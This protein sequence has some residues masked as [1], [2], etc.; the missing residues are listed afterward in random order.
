MKDPL[1][2]FD[3]APRVALV[4]DIPMRDLPGLCLTALELVRRGCKVFL[5]PM[6][7]N[8]EVF[9]L[10]PDFVLLNYLRKVSH[11]FVSHLVSYSIP[12]GVIDTEGGPGYDLPNRYIP[13]LCDD[14]VINDAAQCVCAWGP[15]MA[16]ALVESRYYPEAAISVTGSPRFGLYSEPWREA[17]ARF[18]GN[19]PLGKKFILFCCNFALTNSRYASREQIIDSL[20]NSYA[21]PLEEVEEMIAEEDVAVGQFIET[22]RIVA[23]EFPH[24]TVVV[25]PHPFESN[26]FY[27]KEL[28][29]ISNV[30]VIKRGTVA[31]WMIEAVAVVQLNC[32]T[33]YD[34]WFA[35]TPSLRPAWIIQKAGL[36]ENLSINFPCADVGEL[37]AA[38][39]RV[40]QSMFD[41][42]AERRERSLELVRRFFGEPD[43][44]AH[45]RVADRILAKFD[46]GLRRKRFESLRKIRVPIARRASGRESRWVDFVTGI[47]RRLGFQATWNFWNLKTR[48]AW[49]AKHDASEKRFG[50]PEV[51]GI[52]QALAGRAGM[53][54]PDVKQASDAGEF[55]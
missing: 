45:E 6:Y 48:R 39:E 2:E 1:P 32:T 46:V 37:V 36:G 3:D 50:A 26:A 27:E 21:R 9:S 20:V 33:S 13:C 8:E 7:L 44:R 28:A 12:F 24:L 15:E 25:R 40:E 34:A 19:E 14:P 43:G 22:I 52:M 29:G 18:P 16:E 17:V 31:G 49:L 5:V 53:K 38:L 47:S 41:P 23:R 35:G 11:G 51:R 42:G 54:A 4:V 30:A 10:A 55:A